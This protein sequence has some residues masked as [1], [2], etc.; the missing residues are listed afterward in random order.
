M[1]DNLLRRNNIDVDYELFGGDKEFPTLAAVHFTSSNKYYSL[2]YTEY[3]N[4]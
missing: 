1:G 4:I 2:P 3:I